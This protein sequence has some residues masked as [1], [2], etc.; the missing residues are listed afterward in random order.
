MQLLRIHLVDLGESVFVVHVHLFEDA[1]DEE[2]RGV[3]VV[4]VVVVVVD[5]EDSD[6]RGFALLVILE[7][8]MVVS[9]RLTL[10]KKVSYILYLPLR[11]I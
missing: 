10:Q 11:L 2:D 4:R 9:I 6:A 3:A 5:L 7:L 8:K 1:R